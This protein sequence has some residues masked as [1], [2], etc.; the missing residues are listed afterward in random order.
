[1][2]NLGNEIFPTCDTACVLV[3][4]WSGGLPQP[5]P[6]V[7]A[8][9][10]FWNTC[11]CC[12]CLTAAS[13]PHALGEPWHAHSVSDVNRFLRCTFAFYVWCG[14][15]VC[16]GRDS[17]V[18]PLRKRGRTCSCFL[19]QHVLHFLVQTTT[20]TASLPFAP[21]CVR[22]LRPGGTVG[23]LPQRCKP[24]RRQQQRAVRP[25]QGHQY[26]CQGANKRVS[27]VAF[28]TSLA[29]KGW[30]VNHCTYKQRFVGLAPSMH[31]PGTTAVHKRTGMA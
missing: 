18:S 6:L 13:T 27:R 15:E 30:H 1:M 14:W 9:L 4:V 26:Y 31:S 23:Q 24:A 29:G 10:R 12:T 8:A 3:S 11:C 7:V 2:S 25:G 20:T 22:G 16:W 17:A 28:S 21:T 19:L 5:R